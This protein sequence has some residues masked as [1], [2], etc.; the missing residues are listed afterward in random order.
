MAGVAH[1]ITL[2]MS[3]IL[4]IERTVSVASVNIDVET[5]S[6]WNTSSLA[7]SETPACWVCK[8]KF[9]QSENKPCAR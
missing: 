9:L 2:T 4:R 5:K 6:G 3:S 7:M 8:Y 1:P